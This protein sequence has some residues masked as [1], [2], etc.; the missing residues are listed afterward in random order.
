MR[1]GKRATGRRIRRLHLPRATGIGGGSTSTSSLIE[2]IHRALDTD[3]DRVPD[4]LTRQWVELDPERRN[5][6]LSRLLP[7]RH[8]R[9]WLRRSVLARLPGP[10]A[11]ALAERLLAYPD[12]FSAMHRDR[13]TPQVVAHLPSPRLQEMAPV[14]A[15]SNA[16][17]ALW[18][19]LGS[20]AAAPVAAAARRV[21]AAGKA[22]ARETTLYLL[23]VD[24]F[25][26][27]TVPAADRHGLI[28]LGLADPDDETRGIAA[29]LA[30]DEA[31]ELLL[32]SVDR[33]V[34][35]P[36]ERAR[37]AA[38]DARFGHD[39]AEAASAATA[40]VQDAPAPLP[41][42]QSALLALAE[43]LPTEEVEGLL[44][45][46]VLDPLEAMAQ[47]AAALLW[48]RHRSPVVAIAAARSPHAPVRAI[49]ER[50][51]HPTLGSPAAGG[52]RPGAADQGFDLYDQFRQA[53]RGGAANERPQE[54]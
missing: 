50:L 48:S 34:R 38:W 47:A 35:D 28:A 22:G 7:D 5:A 45:E 4:H 15:G 54:P 36:A 17:A 10:E 33:W 51:L 32:E 43:Q 52:F 21:F 23:L 25:P 49:A 30:V 19:R 12:D 44:A 13:T 41:A 6:A 3:P 39:A 20:D 46:A 29:D 40:L 2:A 8:A 14:L 31:P 42:R 27:V 26:P 9:R 24:R 53:M 16:A 1:P 37:M 11:A 18:E